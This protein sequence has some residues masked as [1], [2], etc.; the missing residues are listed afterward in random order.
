[1]TAA[2]LVLASCLAAQQPPAAPPADPFQ[3]AMAGLQDENPMIRRRS[4]DALGQLRRSE[5]VPALIKTLSDPHP[6]VRAM[7]A[8]SLGL[9]RSGQ[10]LQPLIETLRSDKE[11]GPRQSA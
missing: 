10:A 5:A 8:D 2:L 3:A 7:A 11:P 9:L 4:A 6:F 1:M